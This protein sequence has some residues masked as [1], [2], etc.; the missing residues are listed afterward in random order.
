MRRILDCCDAPALFLA[1]S[2]V[3]PSFRNPKEGFCQVR[4]IRLLFANEIKKKRERERD[5][6]SLDGRRSK[7]KGMKEPTPRGFATALIKTATTYGC[8][9]R[10]VDLRAALAHSPRYV[11]THTYICTSLSLSLSVYIYIYTHVDMYTCMYID[12][13]VI[14]RIADSFFFRRRQKKRN[15]KYLRVQSPL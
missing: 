8:I 3:F 13:C 9:Q 11:I 5:R 4:V 2:A 6:R 7:K 12:V 10:T 15:D 1:F 14:C